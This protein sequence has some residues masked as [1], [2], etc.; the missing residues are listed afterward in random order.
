MMPPEQR[1][2]TRIILRTDHLDLKLIQNDLF[3]NL[4]QTIRF[5]HAR[6]LKKFE[7]GVQPKLHF[8]PPRAE[9]HAVMS[10]PCIS[11]RANS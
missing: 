1:L 3:L 10:Q 5:R 11:I 6:S 9:F 2:K 8:P 4:R 7:T